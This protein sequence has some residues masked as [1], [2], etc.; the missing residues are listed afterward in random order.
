MAIK[1]KV[2][3]NADAGFP[4]TL[5]QYGVDNFGVRYGAQFDG[6]ALT[7]GQAAAK[8][9]QA[10]M[11]ALACEG[12][13]DNREPRERDPIRLSTAG[14]KK[15]TREIYRDEGLIP[16]VK[17]YRAALWRDGTGEDPGLKVSIDLIRDEWGPAK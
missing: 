3:F 9:G 5:E 17:Y 1:H 6:P 13:I 15:H 7:Y 14:I 2:E 10:L 16:A 8:L 4:I 12:K 11:H